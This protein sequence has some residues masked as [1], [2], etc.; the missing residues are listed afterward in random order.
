[1]EWGSCFHPR[2]QETDETEK[3]LEPDQASGDKIGGL[4]TLKHCQSPPQDIYQILKLHRV[5]G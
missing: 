4:T 2:R 3:I 5:W 1:M